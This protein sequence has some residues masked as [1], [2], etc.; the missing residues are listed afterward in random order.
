MIFFDNNYLVLSF[1]TRVGLR[2]YMGFK[3]EKSIFFHN[4]LF[5]STTSR[6]FCGRSESIGIETRKYHGG[7][8]V[9]TQIWP[10]SGKNIIVNVRNIAIFGN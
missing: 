2:G 10:L 7:A 5:N 9:P 1:P 6:I 4:F 3:T 8:S